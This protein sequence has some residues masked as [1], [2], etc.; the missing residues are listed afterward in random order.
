MAQAQ[1]SPVN[2]SQNIFYYSVTCS[3]CKKVEAF[4][5]ANGVNDKYQI[6]QK[7]VSGNPANAKELYDLSVDLSEKTDIAA[8]HPEIVSRMK[9]ELEDWQQSVLRSNLGEDYKS[10]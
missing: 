9:A 2:K 1:Y 10:K 5:R 4:F 7:E 8:H 3:H 6:I